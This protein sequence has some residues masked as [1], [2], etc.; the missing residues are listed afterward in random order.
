MTR[1]S[2]K[3]ASQGLDKGAGKRKGRIKVFLEN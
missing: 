3:K 2:G 1:E